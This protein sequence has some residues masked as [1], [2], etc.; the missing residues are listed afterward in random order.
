M[1]RFIQ[2]IYLDEIRMK[3][4]IDFTKVTI[5]EILSYFKCKFRIDVES[6]KNP[7]KKEYYCGITNNIKQNLLRHNI[8]RYLVC[9]QCASFDVAK[10]V[11]EKLG[12]EGFDIGDVKHGGNGGAEDSVYVYMVKKEE[13]FKM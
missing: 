1:K 12:R 3:N 5:D 13:G 8:S 6:D 7:N 11:E 10:E 4:P 2:E 9:C